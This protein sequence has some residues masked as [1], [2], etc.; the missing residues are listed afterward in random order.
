MRNVGERRRERP[1]QDVLTDR[2]K[3]VLTH[4]I[5]HADSDNAVLAG[6]LGIATN[7][8]KW[9]LKKASEMLGVLTHTLPC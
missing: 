6:V 3:E 5:R 8:Y 1:Q 7:T 4:A 9:H 2:E